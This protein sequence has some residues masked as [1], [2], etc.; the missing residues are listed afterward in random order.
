M[1]EFDAGGVGGEVPVGLGVVSVAIAFPGGDLVDEGLFVGDAAIE[2]LRGQNTEFGLGEIEPAAVLWRVVPFEALGQPAGLGGWEGLV[3]RGLGM[4]AE[5]V[6][7]QD[8]PGGGGEADVGDVL[9]DLGVVGG[10]PAIS[11]GWRQPSSGANTMNRLATPLR[12]YS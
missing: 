12:S 4:G 11:D 9:E 2:A 3:E 1:L 8:D 7:D 5:I 6:L 10:G